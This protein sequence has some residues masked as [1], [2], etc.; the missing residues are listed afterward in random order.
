MPLIPF[1]S[2]AQGCAECDLRG[3]CGVVSSLC[4]VGYSECNGGSFYLGSRRK[5]DCSQ[6]GRA[7]RVGLLVGIVEDAMK[8]GGKFF[9]RNI[10]GI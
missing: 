9:D 4:A 2:C 10:L 1:N 6:T 8:S 7:W 3:A 5:I